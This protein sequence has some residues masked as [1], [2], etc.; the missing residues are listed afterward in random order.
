VIE[1]NFH[2]FDSYVKTNNGHTMYFDI[3]TDKNIPKKQDV[4]NN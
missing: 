2:V 3:I 1:I 4:Q